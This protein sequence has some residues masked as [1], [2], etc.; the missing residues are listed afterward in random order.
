M[1]CLGSPTRREVDS[2][3][4]KQRWLSIGTPTVRNIFF[5]SKYK[6]LLWL[7]LGASSFPLHMFWNSTVF[8]TK[9]TNDYL[10][11]TVTEDFLQGSQWAIPSKSHNV[12]E[13]YADADAKAAHYHNIIQDLQQEAIAT[14]SGNSS[15]GLEFLDVEDCLRAYD[16]D[17]VSDRQHVLL[18]VD[19]NATATLAAEVDTPTNSSVL[20]IYYN[21]FFTTGAPLFLWMCNS[22][23][24][25]LDV[26]NG[27]EWSC[28]SDL[29]KDGVNNWIPGGAGTNGAVLGSQRDAPVRYCYSQRTPEQCKINIV[30]L[31]LIVVIICNAIKIASFLYTL[32][33]TKKDQPLCTTGDAIQSF[34]KRPDPYTQSRC[35]VAKY[36]YEKLGS[37]EWTTRAPNVGDLWAGGRWRWGKAVNWW[38]WT[39]YVLC[40]CSVIIFA[41]FYLPPFNMPN[42]ITVSQS[43]I[44]ALGLGQPHSTLAA[45]KAGV[46]NLL[47]GF[48]CANAP[49]L[50]V[51]YI[52][53]ALNN[54]MTTMLAMAEWCSY[55]TGPRSQ[56]KA[57]RVSSPVPNTE[58]K[59]TYTLS[60]PLKWGIPTT[61]CVTVL[62]WL[63]SEMVFLARID[64]Y[65][66]NSHGSGTPTSVTDIFYSPLAM[67]IAVSLG[68]A[69]VAILVII[70]IFKKYPDSMPLAGCCS[71]SIA[72]A[73][74]PSRVLGN[75]IGNQEFPE[76]LVYKKI[77]WGVVE[78]PEENMPLGIGHATFAAEDVSP[79]VE[80]KLYA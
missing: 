73:C 53:L 21:V 11:V 59:S 64:V 20:A 75:G 3:H 40:V 17:K 74:Q 25:N 45:T 61:I 32:R 38:Q 60:V 41:G 46:S 62:H 39:V 58:Q 26:M 10:A 2:A 29:L 50:I 15:S 30:P 48:V 23:T 44:A 14:K 27:R 63:I 51:S 9:S 52:Y 8:E 36:D 71:A 78:S 69:M 57:L 28:A 79:L 66:V 67:I 22:S 13:E 76:D 65:D 56:P 16:Q 7:V 19:N 37:E 12:N 42:F 6:S 77:Q 47:T 72:A 80:G 35:L 4:S 18:V 49:Q 54:M 70:G 55:T 34:L 31:F 43:A 1:Q 68:S 33:I 5:I 24:N